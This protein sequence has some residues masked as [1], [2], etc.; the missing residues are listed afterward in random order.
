M[1]AQI[2]HIYMHTI[3]K[4]PIQPRPSSWDPSVPPQ[5]PA[6]SCLPPAHAHH[7]HHAPQTPGAQPVSDLSLITDY[8]QSGGLVDCLVEGTEGVTDG[9]ERGKVG[10]TD[11]WR[12]RMRGVDE[13]KARKSSMQMSAAGGDTKTPR[14]P[15]SKG[16]Q[17][18]FWKISE[19]EAFLVSSCVAEVPGYNPKSDALWH[20]EKSQFLRPSNPRPPAGGGKAM[21]PFGVEPRVRSV[22]TADSGKANSPE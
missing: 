4:R 1:P 14:I 17:C 11:V 3:D 5:S 19:P 20:S 6:H 16:R 10:E 12:S 13:R 8:R 22:S 7:A 21:L 9:M 18:R 15:T 2:R